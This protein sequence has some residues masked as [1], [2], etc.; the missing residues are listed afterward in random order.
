[1]SPLWSVQAEQA[2]LQYLINRLDPFLAIII[3]R[4]SVTHEMRKLMCH[5]EVCQLVILYM[6]SPKNWS[7]HQIL[8]LNENVCLSWECRK[9]EFTIAHPARSGVVGRREAEGHGCTVGMQTPPHM[10]A[11]SCLK[12]TSFT[13]DQSTSAVRSQVQQ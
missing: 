13:V 4:F 11:I 7:I 9:R 12:A 6:E 1:M 3:Q 5:M 2:E 8:V 10:V